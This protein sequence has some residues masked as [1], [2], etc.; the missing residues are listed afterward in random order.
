MGKIQEMSSRRLNYLNSNLVIP[1]NENIIVIE[2][3]CD[4]TTVS[5]N[6]FLIESFA[7][8]QFNVEDFYTS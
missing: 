8:I 4:Q 2:N 7:G 5:I 3:G 1:F 6:N